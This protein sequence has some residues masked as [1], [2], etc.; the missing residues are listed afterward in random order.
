MLMLKIQVIILEALQI[1]KDVNCPHL[2]PSRQ[3][4][5]WLT[6]IVP[7]FVIFNIIKTHRALKTV[8][9]F[10]Q[11][12]IIINESKMQLFSYFIYLLKIKIF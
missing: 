5:Y 9:Q 3:N 12:I 8:Y 6:G 7:D 10:D 2:N 1:A 11:N 4:E